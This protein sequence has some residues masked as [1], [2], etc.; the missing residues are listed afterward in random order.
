MKVLFIYPGIAYV[1]YNSYDRSRGSSDADPIY[2][3]SILGAVIERDGHEVELLDLR[4]LESEQ[5]LEARLAASDAD[6]V[7][8]TV[9]TPSFG[10]ATRVAA[11]AKRLGKITIAGGIHATV[12]PGDFLEHDCWDYIVC[13]EAEQTLPRLLADLAAKTPIANRVITGPHLENLDDLPLPKFFPHYEAKQRE[14]Y[15]IETARGCPGKCSYC[16]SG[17]KA[18][19]KKMRFR[20][21][22]HV[23]RE[24]EFAYQ[25]FQFTD[26]LFLDVCA[27]SNKRLIQQML[28]AVYERFPQMHV[29]I[30]ARVDN[31]REDTARAL[32]RFPKATVWLGFESA[33]DRMLTFLQ[34][35][36][37]HSQ[38]VAAAKLCR[39]YGLEI[40]ANALMGVPT[41]T[42]DDI[43]Q[44]YEFFRDIN[45][46]R[47]FA[48][49]LSP[50]PG[51]RIH[52]YCLDNGLLSDNLPHERYEVRN[53]FEQGILNNIDY[54][55][56][57]YWHGQ[58]NRLLD[59]DMR[60]LAPKVDAIVDRLAGQGRRVAIFGAGSHT[61]TLFDQTR[62]GA[63]NPVAIFDNDA[64]KHC[65]S[66]R[67]IP[68]CSPLR[69]R[70]LAVDAVVISSRAH[71]D[72][73][74]RQLEHSVPADVELLRLYA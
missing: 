55:A 38:N 34:K 24:L 46:E 37:T 7:G 62:I 36:V 57:H 11:I 65:L 27:T 23:M 45:P 14:M 15:A 33:S 39:R 16:V 52:R 6:V 21:C 30:Q 67:G 1:G 4:Q 58:F 61:E 12:A 60:N 72:A 66:F 32:A 54:D 56:V 51:T 28:D 35:G 50:F 69:L 18:F 3:F 48:N 63:L 22:A 2:C 20:S 42:D 43:R 70:N 31:F 17:E 68:V 8:L 13:G 41:E 29:T 47:L 64:Q 71:E 53:V 5:D 44:T 49:I 74:Y 73:I 25:R 26:L 59:A 19:Y 10:I 40:G 9:Q